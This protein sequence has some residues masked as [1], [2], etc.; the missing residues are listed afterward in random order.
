MSGNDENTAIEALSANVLE[1]R[2]ENFDQATIEN[3]RYRIIDVLG[4]GI[5]GANAAGNAA[6]VKL[7]KDWGGKQEAPILVHGG[8]VPAH[9]AAMVNS[10]MARSFDFEALVPQIDGADIPA[11]ISGTT[12]M[13]AITLGEM[14]DINGKEL[15][16]ALLAG[17]DAAIRVLAAAGF[18]LDEGW[19]D[20]GTI[21]AIGATA[22]AGRLLGLNKRQMRHA[23]GITLNQLAAT[24]Q[25]IWDGST[26]FKLPQGLS[27]RNGIFSAQLA[28]AG[29]TGPEDMLLS[30][31]GYYSL[32][33]GG[34]NNPEILTKD[35]GKKYYTESLFKPY[36]S[37]RGTH[38]PIDCAVAIA[39]QHNI[40][41][42]DIEEVTLYLCQK[43]LDIFMSQPFR[44]GEFPHG[45]AAFNCQ[46]TVAC[47]LLRGD[48]KP[49]HFSE[50]AI[51]DPQLN[52]LITKIR[53]AELP[54]APFLSAKLE[55]R[56]KDGQI[57]SEFTDTP[58]GD[59]QNNPLSTDEIKDKYRANVDFSQ[60]VSRDNAEKAL[61][62]LANL[63]TLDSVNKI[64][65][66]L[67][68]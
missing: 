32:Y 29:W 62:L 27:A 19:D 53:L 11:H 59:Q 47:G 60:T 63:E 65:K 54:G 17:D 49:E 36:P 1:T 5:G 46:Y 39:R 61:E 25:N 51:R 24:V 23:F 2:F 15:I 44:I 55:V 48:V 6:L 43:G 7:V 38:P 33:T 41:A 18:W 3:A 58:K 26:A 67:V 30:K 9:N 20:T 57:F 34:C 13:T 22:I 4:C 12:V 16:T 56:M 64:V 68:I 66:L 45:N 28:K 31:Y 14:M 35:L 40:K 8:K 21:N 37:C 50:A 10:I 52:D 42:D